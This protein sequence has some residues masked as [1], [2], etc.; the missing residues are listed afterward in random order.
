[1]TWSKGLLAAFD[2]ETT[3]TEPLEARIVTATVL[4][5]GATFGTWSRQWLVDPGIEIPEEAAAIHGITT[6]K[7]R[8][9]GRAAAYAIEEIATL[10]AELSCSGLPL[11]G[12]NIAYDLTVLE[13]ELARHGLSSLRTRCPSM[14]AIDPLVIDRHVDR[15]RKGKRTLAVTCEFYGVTLDGAHES[16]SDAL[17]AARLAW[18][19]PRLNPEVAGMTLAELQVAQA[20]WHAEWA[21]NFEAYLR[22]QGNAEAQIEREWPVRRRS[23]EL[24][25]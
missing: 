21:A 3:G 12:Y 14:P 16:H 6:E 18:L 5:A 9:E 1:M 23:V 24:A 8:A 17:A 4:V 2:V 19:L 20:Q 13:E 10:L 15:Y 11:V 25:S 22:A 7:A